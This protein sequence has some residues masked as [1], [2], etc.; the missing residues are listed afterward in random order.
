MS[1]S[2]LKS[3]QIDLDKLDTP[4]I[5]ASIDKFADDAIKHN[6]VKESYELFIRLKKMV[7]GKDPSKVST[8]AQKY[9]PAL[10]KLT[11]VV[12]HA[13]ADGD[14]LDFIRDY[15]VKYLDN[16][17][18]DLFARVRTK[19]V[20]TPI[21]LRDDLKKK[22]IEILKQNRERIG[23]TEINIGGKNKSPS[24]RNW[25]ASYENFAGVGY[26]DKI[27]L[28]KYL[29]QNPNCQKLSKSAK[30]HLHDLLYFYD[31]MRISSWE[32]GALDNYGLEAVSPGAYTLDFSVA[33]GSASP[34][35]PAGSKPVT[36]VKPGSSQPGRK[37]PGTPAPP[38]TTSPGTKSPASEVGQSPTSPL[39]RPQPPTSS[40]SKS[41]NVVN[42]KQ[43]GAA[44]ASPLQPPATAVVKEKLHLDSIPSISKISIQYFR[45][46]ASDPYQ[47]AEEI[48]AEIFKLIGA[49]PLEKG[50]AK[51]HWQQSPLYR[52][53]IDMGEESMKTKKPIKEIS[54]TK[55]NSDR[56]YLTEAEFKAIVEI[57]RMF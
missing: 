28:L 41:T 55:K 6:Y 17:Y 3:Y 50:E 29:S 54:Q 31:L 19:L 36:K 42:L 9:Q 37:Q 49:S 40:A 56:P 43:T 30:D 35:S 23:Q 24:V 20:G 26:H 45:G 53:Y 2:L 22:I 5:L 8:Q 39:A 18:I 44:K 11:L 10:A 51:Q 33:A 14:F 7:D 32:V 25:L 12:L 34:A 1:T 16:E 13:L 48:K 57:S 52:L 4:G 46:L 38:P 27:Q 21:E 47:A 15:F